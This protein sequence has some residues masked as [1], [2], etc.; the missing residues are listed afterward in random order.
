MTKWREPWWQVPPR[1]RGCHQRKIVALLFASGGSSTVTVWDVSSRMLGS[2]TLSR[3]QVISLSVEKSTITPSL[4]WSGNW[5][6]ALW[7]V[8]PILMTNSS[9]LLMKKEMEKLY[10]DLF[11]SLGC[12][13]VASLVHQLIMKL[14]FT[15]SRYQRLINIAVN[16]TSTSL[17]NPL[18]VVKVTLAG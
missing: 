8:L 6:V 5:Q 15:V 10:H 2:M 12:E 14:C 9:I 13:P 4:R 7:S 17:T 11:C 3:C 16:L 18:Q 1:P